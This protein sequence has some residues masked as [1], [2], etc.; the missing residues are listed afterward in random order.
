MGL[1]TKTVFKRWYPNNKEWFINKGYKFTKIKEEFEVRVED[2][3]NGNGSKVNVKCDGK[4]CKNPYLPPMQ[5]ANY[6]LKVH[7]DGKYYCQKCTRTLNKHT[8]EHKKS[9]KQWC[10]ENSRQDILDRWDYDLNDKRPED[11]I[12]TSRGKKNKGYWFKC[13]KKLGHKSELQHIQ[14][15]TH[16]QKSDIYCQQCKSTS[17]ELWVGSTTPGTPRI[18][19]QRYLTYLVEPNRTHLQ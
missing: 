8:S 19:N 12:D 16:G 7:N 13:D 9:F 14:N 1:I 11:I 17:F 18:R 10:I 2:L 15:F 6:F 5:W 4:D 3:T